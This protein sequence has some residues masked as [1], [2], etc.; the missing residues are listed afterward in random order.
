[1]GAGVDAHRAFH[2]YENQTRPDPLA[3]PRTQA[4]ALAGTADL[5]AQM[6]DRCHLSRKCRDRLYPEFVLAES[7]RDQGT[8]GALRVA[9]AQ[10][11]STAATPEFVRETRVQRLETVRHACQYIEPLFDNR[12]LPTL[13]HRTNLVFL[14]ACCT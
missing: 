6:A 12:N 14:H 2:G 10:V 9:M 11:G 4:R 8:D 3:D 1:M 7:R 5:I 13:N